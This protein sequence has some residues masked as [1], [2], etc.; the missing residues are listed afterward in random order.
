MLGG[1]PADQHP[2]PEGQRQ[3]G[4]WLVAEIRSGGNER[5]GGHLSSLC[6]HRSHDMPSVQRW[7]SG[8]HVTTEPD[9]ECC[10]QA[11][12]CLDGKKRLLP[13]QA[14]TACGSDVL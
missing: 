3:V 13:E 4:I 11:L 7:A 1:V 12:Q 2:E 8:N 14:L 9:E 10:F 5:P 6:W